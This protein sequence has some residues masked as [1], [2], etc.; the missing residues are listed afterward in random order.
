M[1]LLDTNAIIWLNRGHRRSRPLANSHGRLYVSPAS[2][3]E[4]QILFEVG[5]LTAP[6]SPPDLARAGNWLIDDP[7]SSAWFEEAAGVGWARDP[8]D[9]LLVAHARLRG[10]RLATGDGDLIERLGPRDCLPL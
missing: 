2:I 7:S 10:W 1:I 5:R 3:L 8:F 4:L 6:M 9:R